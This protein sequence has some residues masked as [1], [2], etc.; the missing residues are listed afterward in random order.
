MPAQGNALGNMSQNTSSPEGAA[1]QSAKSLLQTLLAKREAGFRGR[2]KYQPPT[3]P[4]LEGLPEPPAGWIW[5]SPE[6][7]AN[8]APYAL[9]IGPFGSNLKVSDYKE[10]GT[11]LIFVR[12]IRAEDFGLS[13]KYVTEKKAEE[14]AAHTAEGGDIL[15]TKMGEPPGD[16]ALYPVGSPNAV[17]TADCIKWRLAE[18]LRYP[19]FF[20]YAIRSRIVQQQIQNRTRGVAQKKISL[21]RFRD[22]AIPLPPLPEQRRIV[23]EIEKQFTRLEAGVAALK[24]VQANLKRYRAAVLKAACEGKLVPTEGE[25]QRSSREGGSGVPPLSRKKS[26]SRDG[27]AT[28]P[29]SYETGADLLARILKERRQKWQGRGKYKEPTAPDASKLPELPEGWVYAAVEQL[30][31]VGEQAV[32]TGPFG[33]NLGRE[34]FI[35]SGV[36]LL[37]ISCLQDTGIKLEKA[38][39][40]SPEKAKELEKYQ[41][42]PGDLLFSRMATVGRA[43]IVGESLRGALFNY[44]IMRLR[45][46]PTV[47]LAKFFMAY[48]RGSAQ[49]D[50]YLREVNHGATRA[51]INTEQLLNMPVAL[52]PLAEQTRIVAEVERL[53][54][55][56][57]ELESVVSANLQRATRL[58]QSILQKA[59]TG[60]LHE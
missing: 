24:R 29:A 3:A 34:D 12:N 41:L 20:V 37:T 17:I 30:G 19:K 28:L 40:I 35:D 14:L 46:E 10:S 1:Q 27:S 2:G 43:G 5:A 58:R 59:F 11:P 9:G 13:T 16:A 54:S 21:E 38:E 44:H 56:V 50:E 36:L 18:D 39:F 26:Q 32:L 7:L 31:I 25:L 4:D 48:V 53:L 52:P 60:E 55:V 57:E 47:L 6:Q 8:A 22:L 15:I 49:V 51:G 23:A 45:I 33:T 42:Q